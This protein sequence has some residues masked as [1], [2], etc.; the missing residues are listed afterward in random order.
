M[1]GLERSRKCPL[2]LKAEV[3]HF[4]AAISMTRDLGEVLHRGISISY[5][6]DT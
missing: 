2:L 3:L 5:L 1:R 6:V 4:S